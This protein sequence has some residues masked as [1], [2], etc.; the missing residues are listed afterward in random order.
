MHIKRK[1]V[2]LILAATLISGLF[3][4]QPASAQQTQDSGDRHPG[5]SS[6]EPTGRWPEVT[7][8]GA[9]PCTPPTYP[10]DPNPGGPA[11][12]DVACAPPY[13][14]GKDPNGPVQPNPHDPD[15][16]NP[17]HYPPSYP[18]PFPFPPEPNSGEG[19]T[20]KPNHGPDL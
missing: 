9:I 7:M 20:D 5:G 15:V 4:L 1:I 10:N 19:P 8:C 11:C 2:R 14:G 16:P 12:G 18:N 3:T 6:R 17:T 13:K